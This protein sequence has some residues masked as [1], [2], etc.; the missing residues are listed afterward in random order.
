[1]SAMEAFTAKEINLPSLTPKFTHSD[2][3]SSSSPVCSVALSHGA[4]KR[5]SKEPLPRSLSPGQRSKRALG[6][7]VPSVG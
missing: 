5:R 3:S 2:G 6:L 7:A 1:M 4:V